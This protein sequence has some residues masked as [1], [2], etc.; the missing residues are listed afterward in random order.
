MLPQHL[1]LIFVGMKPKKLWV[2][3]FK[4]GEL[5]FGE[6]MN[7]ELFLRID[8]HEI[9]INWCEGHEWVS[10]YMVTFSTSY[11]TDSFIVFTLKMESASKNTIFRSKYDGETWS[12]KKPLKFL[13]AK[14]CFSL[15]HKSAQNKKFINKNIYL[16][17][18]RD[19]KTNFSRPLFTIISKPKMV[20]LNTDSIL[21]VK[22]MYESVK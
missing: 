13:H 18:W 14:D 16:P 17:A 3:K 21:R 6:L 9:W 2:F 10:I 12:I 5:W 8:L 15:L 1:I 19:I 20:F 11:L 4:I 7:C 22:I